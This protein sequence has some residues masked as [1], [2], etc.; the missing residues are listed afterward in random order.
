VLRI[1]Q[2]TLSQF[3]CVVL[4]FLSR[5]LENNSVSST[6]ATAANLWLPICLPH[7]HAAG[8]LYCYT[9][10]LHKDYPLTLALIS[11][12]GTTDQFQTFR[13]QAQSIQSDLGIPLQSS[14]I[15]DLDTSS[16]GHDGSIGEAYIRSGVSQSQHLLAASEDDYVVVS[17]TCIGVFT[18]LP[19]EKEV[20]GNFN[21]LQELSHSQDSTRIDDIFEDYLAL[22]D[23]W[24]FVFRINV[25]IVSSNEHRRGK[26]VTTGYLPQC[27]AC[28]L[29]GRG[30]I[31]SD[32]TVEKRRR[33]WNIYQR[34]NLRLRLGSSTFEASMDGLEMNRQDCGDDQQHAPTIAKDCLA[35]SLLGV[36]PKLEGIAFMKIGVDTFFGM[37]G[38]EFEL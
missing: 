24:H 29:D 22:G 10:S 38:Q 17:E 14:T 31:P 2:G 12:Q 25:P 7:V 1:K 15:P 21:L 34:L 3:C 37:S 16:N 32:T 20:W 26:K 13:K 18:Y 28:P 33:L 19:E 11:T 6:N 8:F 4:L 23:A 5:Q 36:P 27:L 35:M 30:G 9:H